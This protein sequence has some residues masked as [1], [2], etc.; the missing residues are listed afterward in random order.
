MFISAHCCAQ[1][2]HYKTRADCTLSDAILTPQ[3][4]GYVA[5]CMHAIPHL[6][7]LDPNSLHQHRAAL[8]A[9]WAAPAPVPNSSISAQAVLAWL[10]SPA[11][12]AACS[13]QELGQ[14]S[15]SGLVQEPY[16][17]PSPTWNSY[18]AA[19]FAGSGFTTLASSSHCSEEWSTQRGGRQGQGGRE[20][21]SKGLC[22]RRRAGEG[23]RKPFT[24]W[25]LNQ[26]CNLTLAAS[27][28]QQH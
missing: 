7:A 27:C 4:M 13:A 3:D 26:S 1:F 24:Y 5:G 18:S 12:P 19:G 28:H 11:E 14:L 9:I 22:K 25:S 23:K 16:L 21:S 6:P 8:E 20:K 10:S 17:D 15:V 2:W